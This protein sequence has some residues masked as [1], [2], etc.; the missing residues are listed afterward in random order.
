MLVYLLRERV[1]HVYLYV[2]GVWQGRVA[3]VQDVHEA[4]SGFHLHRCLTRYNRVAEGDN[5]GTQALFEA[6]NA[7]FHYE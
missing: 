1:F 4:L 7:I 6:T 3:V 2:C 5:V